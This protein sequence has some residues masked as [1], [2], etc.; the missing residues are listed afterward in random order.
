MGGELGDDLTRAAGTASCG[1]QTITLDTQARDA[2]HTWSFN[3]NPIAGAGTGSTL[4]VTE[5]GVYSVFVEFAPGCSTQDSIIV[6]FR[7]SPE[8][9]APPIDLAG[10]SPS[11][12]AEFNL[13]L[14]TPLVFGVQDD[15]E[16]A[17]T[18]HNSLADAET[19]DNPIPNLNNY[20][21]TYGE[22]IFV[23]IDDIATEQCFVIDSFLLSVFSSVSSEDVVF[24]LCDSVNDGD[25]TNG[26]A[27]FDLSL[28]DSQVLGTQDPTQFTVS[29]HANQNDADTGNNPL[30]SVISNS[31]QSVIFARV[32]NNSNVDCYA[33]S[34]ITL[35]VNAL[36]SVVSSVDL[37]QCDVDTDGLSEFNLTEANDLISTNSVNETFTY[38]E[39]LV[40]AQNETNPILNELNYPNTDSSANPDILF[41]R[42]ENANTCSRIA[43]LELFVSTSQIPT[44]FVIPTYEEC[45]D[46]RVDDNISDG[47]T[48]FDF[49]NA[50]SQIE[51]IFPAGQNITVTYYETTAD[52]LAETNPIL[53]ISNHINTASPFS[54]TI[55]YR[56]D[57]NTDNSCQG[58][59]EFQLRVINPT[60]RTDIDDLIACD[61]ITI[62]D[63][64]EEFDLT[65]NEAFIFDGNPNLFASYF[66]S[67]N[68]ALNNVMGN[69]IT[70]P[71]AYNNVNPTETIFVRV[72]DT[73]TNCFAVVDFD[74]VV[75]PLP[76]VVAVSSILEC[77]NG[78]DGFFDFDL[79]QKRDEILNGQDPS[80]FT[81]SFHV[82]Q[83]DADNLSNPQ[84]D[85]FTNTVN[86]QEIFYAITNN[87]TLCSN[88]SGSFFI[89]VLE[90][91]QANSDGEPLDFELCDDNIEND[92]VAQFDL[93]TLEGEILDGQDS[94]DYTITFHFSQQ[95]ALDNIEPLPLLYENLT[96]P[97][98]I[99]VRVSNNIS[100]DVCFEVQ[101]IPLR[102]NPIPEFDLEDV[103]V[104]C[105]TFNGTEVVPVPPILDTGLSSANYS[106]EWRLDGQVLT[107]ETQPILIPTQGG[108]YTVEV[109]D[110][111]T[112][113]LTRC[114]NM[115]EAVVIESEIP[116]VVAEV[117]SQ[118]F[119]G[120]HVIEA[121]TA[122][123]G[124]F[125]FS[126]DNG[127]W[128]DTG[129][130]DNVT[131]GT[132]TVYARDIDGCGIGSDTVLVIDYPLYFTPNG[133]GNHDTWNI[134]G[135][136]TQPSAKIYIFD[137]YGKLLKQLSP[138]GS[139]WDG[140]YQG[141]RMPTD[142]YWFTVEYIEPT[143]G[144]RKEQRAHFTLKR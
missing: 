20:S 134:V 7:T 113:N 14:N 144:E 59:G 4:E 77:E 74:I 60:P 80:Q 111:T 29:Y 139:G 119:S 19:G 22:V 3:G 72:E 105:T 102:V 55:T 63:L 96:N 69:E 54:Q 68:D 104:L 83:T 128:Q 129:F 95:N 12:M 64:S 32:Q 39:T 125:E 118:A 115:D 62:G 8:I 49:S 15:T 120:N 75:N 124:D 58:L 24:E 97:Q 78:T 94:A 52:A 36:P 40:D 131:P 43:Q 132:H 28:I 16:F 142:D 84:P 9:I 133:D 34:T 38:Y 53:D 116:I 137:R 143:T 10:C 140:T 30:P 106:F 27:D 1:G 18:Y 23:R 66:L 110:I 56:V 112:S 98:I 81:V 50:T 126:L 92:G 57:N 85:I 11:G 100:P 26:I 31:T 33:T 101:E 136:D 130:F 6:E 47:V 35:Q 37:R 45:D 65:Q 89:E 2:I 86:P 70:L 25:D 13:E 121:I 122:N 114:T 21:A 108:T 93:A 103:Y 51:A 117:T 88:S 87:I 73:N 109:T 123:V 46:T 138:T 99:W 107:S 82:S 67:F 44:G 61:D 79:G 127:P 91:A 41:V 135:I 48:T 71:S 76:E 90:G 5:A 42:V 17:I 141:N